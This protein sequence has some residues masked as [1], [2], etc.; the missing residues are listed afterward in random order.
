M[1]DW[2]PSTLRAAGDRSATSQRIG[3]VSMIITMALAAVHAANPAGTRIDTLALGFLWGCQYDGLSPV[4][5]DPW[6]HARALY[7]LVMLALLT[8]LGGAPATGGAPVLVL[9]LAAAS[10]A[11]VAGLA[12]EW[13][14]GRETAPWTLLCVWT[15]V[16]LA[17]A[18]TE[19]PTAAA[20][21]LSA[22][23]SAWL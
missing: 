20:L 19:S 16:V 14:R 13:H 8:A 10:L 11:A 1:T 22:A 4:A 15:Y 3:A 12:V 17:A 21:M 2:M 5:S 6:R 9:A 23:A 18:S 7:H